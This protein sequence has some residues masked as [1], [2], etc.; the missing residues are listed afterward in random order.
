MKKAAIFVIVMIIVSQSARLLFAA[1]GDSG[2]PI[3]TLSYI[4]ERLMPEIEQKIEEKTAPVFNVVNIPAGTSVICDAGTELILR[5]GTASVIATDKGGIADVTH[6][7]DLADGGAVPP[8]SLLIVPVADGRGIRAQTD[9]IVMIK[10][11]HT[12]E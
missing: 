11:E 4:M 6:G 9:I 8:N 3:V 2:D 5:M 7:T 1:P 12:A 10:G